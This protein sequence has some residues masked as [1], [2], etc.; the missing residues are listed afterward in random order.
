MKKFIY[1]LLIPLCMG[2]V[3]CGD[4]DDDTPVSTPP[5]TNT[6]NGDNGNGNGNGDN[7]DNGNGNN[8]SQDPEGTVVVNM[9]SG[10]SGNYIDIG[11]GSSIQ[12]NAANNFVGY[13]SVEFASVGEVTGLSKVTSIPTSGWAK[14]VAVV[15]GTGYVARCHNATYSNGTYTYYYK[16]ARLY[17]VE[18][19]INTAGGI[20]GATVKYQSPFEPTTTP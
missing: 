10:S 7:G 17:V 12:I 16:Y 18:R 6:G 14:S 3:A 15:P 1:L 4:G 13:S 8:G 9:N 2:F 11:I 5:T 19:T 20:M